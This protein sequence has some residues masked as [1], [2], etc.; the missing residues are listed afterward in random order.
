MI[1]NIAITLRGLNSIVKPFVKHFVFEL[2]INI[3]NQIPFYFTVTAWEKMCV[4]H[5]NKE[6]LF[7]ILVYLN[8]R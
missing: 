1:I 2:N 3:S 4:Q 5:V 8:D 6:D 7:Y